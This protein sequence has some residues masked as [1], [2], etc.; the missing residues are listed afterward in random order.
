MRISPALGASKPAIMLRIVVLPQPL[1]P[2]RVR[3]SPRRIARSSAWTATTGPKLL[4]TRRSST[5]GAARSC[6]SVGIDREDAAQAESAVGQE[7][8]ERGG[9]DEEGRDRG[10][11]RVA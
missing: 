6:C 7:H 2:S 8:E 11:G 3:S 1:G 4:L 9:D 10:D 5:A